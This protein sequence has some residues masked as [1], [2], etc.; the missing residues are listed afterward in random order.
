MLQ[1]NNFYKV[2]TVEP[3][4]EGSL[5]VRVELNEKHKIFEGHFPGNPVVPG[6]CMVQMIKEMLSSALEKELILVTGDNLKFMN[7]V[8]P[9]VNKFLDFDINYKHQDDSVIKVNNTIFF[10]DKVFFKFSGTFR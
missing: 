3:I 5:K 2:Q 7:I 9:K 4:A 6:V 10:E 8:N 1:E